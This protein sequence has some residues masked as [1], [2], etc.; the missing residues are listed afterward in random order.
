MKPVFE[1]NDKIKRKKNNYVLS[2]KLR[3]KNKK[4]NSVQNET[5]LVFPLPLPFHSI[6]FFKADIL[7]LL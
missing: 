6:S 1:K 4:S 2:E 3:G 7:K 5:N